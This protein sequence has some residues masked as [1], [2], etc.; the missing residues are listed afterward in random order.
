MK[1]MRYTHTKID[2][3]FFN[4]QM[5]LV[6]KSIG[7]FH[8][9]TYFEIGLQISSHILA[10]TS[11]CINPLLYAFLSENFRKAFRK[12]SPRMDKFFLGD[13]RWNFIFNSL[14][15]VSGYNG[16]QC[17]ELFVNISSLRS[18]LFLKLSMKFRRVR[19]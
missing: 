11:S 2:I 13:L 14:L 7:L 12:V 17:F 18:R 9:C 8:P 1:Y 10:Y 15:L 5:I 3:L 19:F 4:F 6:L 16:D